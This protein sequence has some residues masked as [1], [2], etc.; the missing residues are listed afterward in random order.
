[1]IPHLI[2]CPGPGQTIPIANGKGAAATPDYKALYFELFRANEQAI[3]LLTAAQQKAEAQVMEEDGKTAYEVS[4]GRLTMAD[5]A[6]QPAPFVIH[7]EET[8]TVE[9]LVQPS[10]PVQVNPFTTPTT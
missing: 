8:H 4:V 7:P 2:F 10:T 1:M 3:R 5:A 9:T 6:P